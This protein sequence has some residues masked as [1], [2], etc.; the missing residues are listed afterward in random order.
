METCKRLR[1][2]IF[3]LLLC[4]LIGGMVGCGSSDYGSVTGT[5]RAE[6]K[7]LANAMVTFTP[8]PAG[9]PSSGLTNENGV[10][11]LI[12]TQDQNGALIGQHTV[13]VSTAVAQGD[14]GKMS[15]EKLPAK[16]NIASEIKKEVKAGSNVIDI[17]VDF[18]GKVIQPGY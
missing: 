18:K 16:Y 2:R 10:Y 13:R 7:P 3:C 12:Y 9:R 15:K 5:V 11:S 14:Y 1:L 8:E 17:E 6:G 4:P